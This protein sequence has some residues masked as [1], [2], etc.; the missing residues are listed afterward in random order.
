VIA[1]DGAA[2]YSPLRLEYCGTAGATVRVELPP[3][4]GARLQLR[5]ADAEGLARP[6]AAGSSDVLPTADGDRT[7]V[8][9]W[10]Q[11]DVARP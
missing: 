4:A 1:G 6:V 10:P 3:R 2:L 11:P 9:R 5:V 7:I 8:S